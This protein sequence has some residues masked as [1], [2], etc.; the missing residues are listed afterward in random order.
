MRAAMLAGILIA[1]CSGETAPPHDIKA[2]IT[3]PS[4]ATMTAGPADPG[5]AYLSHPEDWSYVRL[6]I[7]SDRGGDNEVGRAPRRLALVARTGG[8]HYIGEEGGDINYRD[9]EAGIECNSFTGVF[10]WTED[11]LMVSAYCATQ[12]DLN[13]WVALS[14][15]Y[16]ESAIA[17]RVLVPTIEASAQ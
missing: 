11:S 13:L 4:V 2:L 15:A 12:P 6:Y 1:G 9:D 10:Q 7:A 5:L 16:V 3:R 14:G 8:S 17:K